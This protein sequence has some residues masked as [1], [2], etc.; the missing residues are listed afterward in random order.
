V[1]WVLSVSIKTDRG[2][3]WSTLTPL[4]S[5]LPYTYHRLRGILLTNQPLAPICITSP[6]A[7]RQRMQ[8]TMFWPYNLIGR[9]SRHE[10]A[11]CMCRAGQFRCFL[12]TVSLAPKIQTTWSGKFLTWYRIISSL[13]SHTDKRGL[14]NRFIQLDNYTFARKSEPGEVHPLLI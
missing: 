7:S 9:W 2:I 1:F 11:Y 14:G 6:R 12:P 8:G 13:L 10:L 3:F 5:P 4:L